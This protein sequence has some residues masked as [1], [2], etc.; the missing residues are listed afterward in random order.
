[1]ALRPHPLRAAPVGAGLSGSLLMP[2]L[3]PAVG[4]RSE[5]ADVERA[6]TG[7]DS[8]ITKCLVKREKAARAAP[9]SSMAL[10]LG[11]SRDALLPPCS[12]ALGH[13][14]AQSLGSATYCGKW[15]GAEDSSSFSDDDDEEDDDDTAVQRAAKRPRGSRPRNKAQTSAERRERNRLAARKSRNKRAQKQ[16]EVV[17]TLEQVTT[18]LDE[19]A[20]RL[21]AAEEAAVRDAAARARL[22]GAVAAWLQIPWRQPAPVAAHGTQ[23]S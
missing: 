23:R 5:A 6:V 7:L 2:E 10:G 20:R 11:P 8:F 9:P 12:G 21:A 14:N 16:A 22:Q 19:T 18:R 17:Q 15:G 4:A 13:G 3:L 1:M